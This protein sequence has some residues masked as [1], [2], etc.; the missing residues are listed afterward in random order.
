VTDTITAYRSALPAGRDGF[1]QLLR[2]EWTKFRTVPGWVIGTAVAALLMVLFGLLGAAASRSVTNSGPGSPD[3]VGHPDAPTGPDG[4]AVTDSFYF[5]HQPLDGDGGITVRVTSLTG[6]VVPLGGGAP[7]GPGGAPATGPGASKPFKEGVQPWTKAGLVIK[8]NTAQGS[9]YAAIM[10]T[11]GHGVR[12]QDN[13][14]RDT[15]GPSGAVSATSPRWLRL[16]RTGGTLTGFASTDGSR[17]TAVGTAHLSGL[18]STVQ[19]GLFVASPGHET[20][21]QFLGGASSTG[22]PTVATATFDAVAVAGRYPGRTWN[23]LDVGGDDKSGATSGRFQVS[24]GRF[25]V[26]GSGDIAPG[27]DVSAHAIERTLVCA[28]V[29]LTVMVVVGVLFITTEYRRGMIRTSLAASPRRGRILAAKATV[30]GAVTFVTGLAAAAVTLPLSV[31]LLRANGNAVYPVT[32]P[33]EVRIVAGTAALLAV[34]AVLALAVGTILRRSVGAVAAVVVL[35]VLPYLLA[36]SAVLPAGPAQWLLRLTPAAAFAIQQS[37]PAYPQVDHAYT[38]AFGYYPL[39]P[40]TGFAVLCG[41][42]VLALGL[43]AYLLRR[44][45]A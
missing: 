31:R 24:G 17:W 41:W 7:G 39:G 13:Y 10:V 34:A 3:R 6:V 15:A 36:I 42:T 35:T 28:F 22:S 40:W 32:W 9:A 12:M 33:T 11:G 23:G 27:V 16:T 4:E 29:T 21:D 1:R 8:E 45:D 25:T 37:I 20:F 14:T 26:T 19:A 38:P 43:A 2:A 44:R 30:I 5:V 18:P